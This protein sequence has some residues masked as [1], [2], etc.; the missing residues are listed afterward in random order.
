MGSLAA[1]PWSA[2]ASSGSLRSAEFPWRDP[3]VV[4][5]EHMMAIYFGSTGSG[6]RSSR[7][8][9]LG[10]F[11]PMLRNRLLGALNQALSALLIHLRLFRF[12]S[13]GLGILNRPHSQHFA[14]CPH[15][16]HFAHCAGKTVHRLLVG[17]PIMFGLGLLHGSLLHGR[18][19]TSEADTVRFNLTNPKTNNRVRMQ[20]VDAGTG[21]EVSRSFARFWNAWSNGTTFRKRTSTTQ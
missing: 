8:A 6:P 13:C 15:S 19:A 18:P 5:H 10:R 1:A 21:E 11:S 7:E 9:S 12:A 17:R 2:R 20:T 14:H 16:Q 3:K 4:N